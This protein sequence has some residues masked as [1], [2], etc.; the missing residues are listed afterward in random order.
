MKDYY[1]KQI[2]YF[3]NAVGELHHGGKFGLNSPEELPLPLQAVYNTLWTDMLS[4]CCY[5]AYVDG[6]PGLLLS[7]LYDDDFC[8]SEG[9]PA[10]DSARYRSIRS[11]GERLERLIHAVN[12]SAEVGIGMDTDRDYEILLFIPT[13]QTSV[14]DV[15][16]LCYLMDTFCYTEAP[17]SLDWN[18]VDL[19][20]FIRAYWA[21]IPERQ[22]LLKSFE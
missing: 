19:T 15:A 18:S 6:M 21:D 9:L 17:D 2:T 4:V 5:I 1:D 7:G 10:E 8:V 20:G 13:E 3:C 11:R 12:G 22:E 16:R 14:P